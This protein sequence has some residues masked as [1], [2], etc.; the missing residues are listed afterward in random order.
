M[1]AAAAGA[2]ATAAE[3]WDRGARV[4]VGVR[5]R[6]FSLARLACLYA[7]CSTF[8]NRA[9]T[10][11]NAEC[12]MGMY[13]FVCVFFCL[14]VLFVCFFLARALVCVCACEYATNALGKENIPSRKKLAPACG[15][16][17]D[18]WTGADE[19]V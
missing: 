4:G 16:R 3:E 15:G 14:F 13:L 19:L 6:F 18:D 5:C 1:V 10:G 2:V 17:S 8:L 12:F 7:A 11:V 9:H